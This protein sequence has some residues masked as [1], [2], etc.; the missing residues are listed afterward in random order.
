[1][2]ILTHRTFSGPIE[3]FFLVL[4][5]L[6]VFILYTFERVFFSWEEGKQLD[7]FQPPAAEEWGGG[8]S[9][10]FCVTLFCLITSKCLDQF[11]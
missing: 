4:K 6:K 11:R 2:K 7:P 3:T 8:N 9:F 10:I 5:V 1:M